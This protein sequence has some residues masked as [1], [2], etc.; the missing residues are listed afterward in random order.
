MDI[1]NRLA[2]IFFGIAMILPLAWSIS[3]V[4]KLPKKKFNRFVVIPFA[5]IWLIISLFLIFT[6]SNTFLFPFYNLPPLIENR[7]D[8]P[9]Y[10]LLVWLWGFFI[11]S[12]YHKWSDGKVTIKHSKRDQSEFI[13]WEII[14][15]ILKALKKSLC[16]VIYLRKALR[17]SESMADLRVTIPLFWIKLFRQDAILDAGDIFLFRHVVSDAV[18]FLGVA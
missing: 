12:W 5:L 2:D 18:E 1:V 6:I 10:L 16:Y 17:V 3:I 13:W 9:L 7:L 15:S 4:L 8:I 11:C 14:P